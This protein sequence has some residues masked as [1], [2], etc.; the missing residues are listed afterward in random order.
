ML[1]C[2]RDICWVRRNGSVKELPYTTTTTTTT[3]NNNNNKT[4]DY[5]AQRGL[6]PPRLRGFLISHNDQPQSV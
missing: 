4:S 6:W 5:A 2:C 1:E 3:T